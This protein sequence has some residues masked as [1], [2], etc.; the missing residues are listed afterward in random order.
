LTAVRALDLAAGAMALAVA[1]ALVVWWARPEILFLILLGLVSARLAL[2]PVAVPA[3]DPRRVVIGGVVAYSLL[4]SFVTVTRHFTFQTHALDLGYYVQLVWNIASGHGAYVSLPPMHAWGDHLS[5]IVYLFVPAFWLAPGPVVLLVAQSV[6]LALGAVP[7]FLLAQRRLGDARPAAAF[8]VLYLLNPSLHGINVRDFHAAALAIPLLLT[9]LYCAEVS[10]PGWF[11]VAAAAAMLCREDAALPVLGIG[12]WLC[13]AHRRWRWGI[14][15]A[16]LALTVLVVDVRYVIPSFRGEHYPHLARYARFGSSLGEIVLSPILHPFRVL[17]TLASGTRPLYLLA[18][19]APLAFLPLLALRDV[20]GALPALAQNL[21]SSDPILFHHRTQYQS[22]VLPFLM[23]AAIGGYARLARRSP[24]QWP[25]LVLVVA[26]I[27]SLALASRTVN[28]LAFDRWW[29]DAEQRMA[30]G[31]MARVPPD[32]RLSAQDPYIAHLSLRPRAAVFPVDIDDADH[33]LINASTYP[34]RNQ[35]GVTM[36]R[37]GR[38]VTIAMPDGR[39]HRY[40]V[41]A[42]AGPHLLLSVV[43]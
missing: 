24:G 2:A 21:F 5:P 4:F 22:F 34:W 33:V 20:I 32:A 36:E 1:S 40:D 37:R 39:A 31:V 13:L 3:L 29:P 12:A 7:V 42:E 9:A 27:A 14:A 16:V 38:D 11:T 15:T 26:G 6:A 28:N 41:V 18:L 19:V 17:G 43:R 30:Y 10:R 8:A 35:P 23:L 25:V